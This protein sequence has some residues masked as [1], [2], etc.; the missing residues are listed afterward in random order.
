MTLETS[1]GSKL[2]RRVTLSDVSV[3]VTSIEVSLVDRSGK[4]VH[5]APLHGGFSLHCSNLENGQL[6]MRWSKLRC[7]ATFRSARGGASALAGA[8]KDAMGAKC[9]K[10]LC[11]RQ[12]VV[13]SFRAG[14]IRVAG[15]QANIQKSCPSLAEQQPGDSIDSSLNVEQQRVVTLVSKGQSV[16]F[17]GGAGVGK[18]HLLRRLLSCLDPSGTARTAS[19]GLAATHIQGTTLHHFVGG[20]GLDEE[21]PAIVQRIRRKTDAVMRWRS[22]RTLVIDEISMIDA[23]LFDKLEHV[24]RIVREDSRVF[25]GLQLIVCGDFLQLPPVSSGEPRFAFEAGSWAA[26]LPHSVVLTQVYRQADAQFATLLNEVRRGVCSDN[27]VRMLSQ[28]CV[29]IGDAERELIDAVKQGTPAATVLMPLRALVTEINSRALR[30]ALGET[31]TFCAKDKGGDSSDSIFGAPQEVVLKQGVQ[32]ILTKTISSSDGLVNGATG[33]V[34]HF[35]GMS[36]FPFVNFSTTRGQGAVLVEPVTWHV[37]C[38]TAVASRE[39]LPLQAAWAISVH[40]SQGM[41]LERVDAA[42]GTVFEYGQAYVALSR[43][44]TLEGLRLLGENIDLKRVVKANPKCV[45][46][47]EALEQ[48]NAS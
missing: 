16:F 13:P 4:T 44:K 39:Q 24:A 23:E 20:G 2:Y 36:G 47:Y 14:A 18:T 8:I 33:V 11:S 22:T 3:S 37:K 12:L 9:N 29:R 21:V 25:G 35:D 26:S 32:V 28:R 27:T 15:R 40:K 19:T 42:L 31:K 48:Q 38:G 6:T 45:A 10:G 1:I 7:Q 5:K 34:S 17:T 30:E 46:F 41:T 43:A